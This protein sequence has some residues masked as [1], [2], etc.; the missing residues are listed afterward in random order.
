MSEFFHCYQPHRFNPRA[1]QTVEQANQII[2]EMRAQGYTLTLRQ[3][4]Y[5]F[6]AR[7]LI[8]NEERQY[9]RLGRLVTLA[10]ESGVMDW[11]AIEDRGRSAY[12]TNP[13]EDPSEV[14]SGIE[15]G[16]IFDQW[17][18][19]DTYL[20][21]W[22][23]KSA[24]EGVV[25]RPCERLDVTYMACKGYLSA[26]EAWRA[27]L[28]FQQAIHEGKRPVLI[29]LGDHDPSGL[30]MTTDNR[31][32]L[33]MFA[34]NHD[35]EVQRI[36]LNM[37]QVEEY[38]PPPNPAKQTDSR[39]AG[40]ALDYGESSWELDA[41]DPAVLD[42][43][44]TDTIHGFIDPD[45]WRETLDMQEEARRPLAALSNNWEQ[46]VDFMEREDLI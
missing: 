42:K 1:R 2:G 29:H 41:L 32:R 8:P 33:R 16:L 23:E 24:L 36:A 12:G 28:R 6:V 31:R 37:H 40:Y 14:V 20:E 11:Y 27:G 46:V 44:I 15:D 43:L 25:S 4:Y 19:Q 13:E 3:L 7:D 22:V 30:H 39:Y 21:V 45:V 5:Q 18:R 35:V 34:E 10:R 38:G 17:A 9:K 26:S